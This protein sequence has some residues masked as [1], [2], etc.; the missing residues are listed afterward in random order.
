MTQRLV[1]ARVR[2]GRIVVL[3]NRF[4]CETEFILAIEFLSKLWGGRS[5]QILTVEPGGPDPLT[6]FRLGESRPD[7]IYGVGIDDNSWMKA[8]NDCCQPR[9]YGALRPDFVKGLNSSHNEDH[10]LVDHALV[11]IAQTKVTDKR[12]RQLLRIVTID[13]NSKWKSYCAATFGVPR[14][15]IG[16]QYYNDHSRFSGASAADFLHLATEFVATWQQSWIDATCH[17]LDQ[18]TSTWADRPPTIVLVGSIVPD[19]SLF[20]NLRAG[21]PTSHPVWM[22]P[23]PFS[24][25]SDAAVLSSIRE[26]LEKFAPYGAKP[27]YCIVTSETVD[28]QECEEFCSQL[29]GVLAGTGVEYVDYARPQNRF[30]VVTQFEYECILAADIRGR[31]FTAQPPRPK[32]FDTLDTQGTWFVDLV[33][34]VKT[35]RAV[36]E[37]QLPP[38]QAMVDLLNG[39]CPPSFEQSLV[40]R[41][42][43]GAECMN[44]RASGNKEVVRLYLPTATE[45]IE[46]VLRDAGIEPVVDEKRSC[47]LPVIERF[48]GVHRAAIA[49]SMKS[50]DIILCLAQGPR[51]LPEIKGACA[52]GAGGVGNGSYS[53]QVESILQYFPERMQR[54]ARG[55]FNRYS[56]H[57][58]P[59]SESVESLLEHWAN[60]SIVTRHWQVGPCRVCAQSEFVGSLNI[61]RRIVCSNCGSTIGLPSRAPLGYALHRAVKHAVDEGVIPVVLT[62]RFLQVMTRRGFMWLP[63][64]KFRDGERRS[65]VDI[66]ACCDGHLVFCEC[67]SLS[68]ATDDA[69]VWANI[70][71]Q[72]I[73]T[74]EVAARCGGSLAVLAALV[75]TFPD[76][77][78]ARIHEGVQQKVPILLLNK[79][80]L[81]TGFRKVTTGT[82]SGS[83]ELQDLLPA[84]FPEHPRPHVDSPRTISSAWGTWSTG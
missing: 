61:Q 13:D 10:I 36:G 46:E 9:G 43:D 57:A 33:Q 59:E 12:R 75:D 82:V 45:V 68:Q 28:A 3:M 21:T 5:A 41:V 37:L 49:L 14:S 4:A 44:V 31:T 67:K 32:A 47:Y 34:D 25:S 48:R 80:D 11:H 35:G 52:L 63:G 20:W 24:E 73:E 15:N 29:K 22:L 23:L 42:G 54:I 50:R 26:W 62:G 6:L 78:V 40:R 79:N 77:V 55:R 64:V 53:G 8:V 81:D 69:K 60:R 16:R 71:Q 1:K 83:L 30:P 18:I 19:L 66:V 27:N 51:T 17:E 56:S 7:F 39:P 74:A 58:T 38:T 70:I 65:D 76:D 2:P 84:P 72:F